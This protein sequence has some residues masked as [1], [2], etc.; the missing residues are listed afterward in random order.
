MAKGLKEADPLAFENGQL[1]IAWTGQPQINAQQSKYISYGP[2]NLQS[3]PY[4]S[5]P[6]LTRCRPAL[7]LSAANVPYGVIE[8]ESIRANTTTNGQ[9]SGWDSCRV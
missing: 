7:P 3:I 5:E 2:L 6:S 1:F 9:S 4:L 8:N